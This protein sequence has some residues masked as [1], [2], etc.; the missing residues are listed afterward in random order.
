MPS[1]FPGMNPFFEQPGIW[2][3]FHSLLLSQITFAISPHVTPRYFVNLEERHYFD[4][5]TGTPSS[6]SPTAYL[7]T[8]PPG[9]IIARI[10]RPIRRKHRWLT[11][12]DSRNREVVTVIEILSPANKSGP[13][14]GQ[15]LRKRRQILRGAAHLVEIDLLRGG[16]RM[17]TDDAP[18]SDYLILVS[19]QPRRP[20]VDVWPVGV[21]Q[22]LPLVPIPL[23]T[24]EAE[25]LL[26]L[27]PLIDTVYDSVYRH[28]LYAA[29]PD[30]PLSP[31]DAEWCRPFLPAG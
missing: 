26:D 21:R 30:P 24:G 16:E 6:D 23:R 15:Y 28:R 4:Y 7:G 22:P 25:P 2:R 9:P 11:L 18:E 8:V 27:K 20:D 29:P 12:R 13:D 5:D 14:R 17:P 1:P 10:P 3:G 31:A 19:R